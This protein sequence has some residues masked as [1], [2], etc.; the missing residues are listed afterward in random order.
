MMAL[1]I[2]YWENSPSTCHSY[3]E[4]PRAVMAPSWVLIF[5]SALLNFSSRVVRVSF[6][7]CIRS[8]LVPEPQWLSGYGSHDLVWAGAHIDPTPSAPEAGEAYLV[9]MWWTLP[10]VSLRKSVLGIFFFLWE[11]LV[12]SLIPP[13]A[14]IKCLW[15]SFV[16]PEE[17][18][19]D[20]TNSPQWS[21]AALWVM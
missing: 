8:E 19:C 12:Y 3:S 21:V 18:A 6:L 5:L 9:Y 20:L 4:A 17:A 2:S 11:Q 10:P 7:I 15:E 14:H 13:T 1:I 16:A